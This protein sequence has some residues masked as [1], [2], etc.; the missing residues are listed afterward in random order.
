MNPVRILVYCDSRETAE[1][2]KKAI[3]ELANGN[4]KKGVPII[5]IDTELFVGARRVKERLDASKKLK[6]LGFLA[7]GGVTVKKPAFLIAT[8]AGEVGIDL[9]ADHM[10]CDLVPWERMV[11]R[12]G[13]VNR[14]DDGNAHIIVIDEG[15][16][17]PKNADK[18]SP[19]ERRDLIAS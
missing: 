3:E 9:D 6:D 13:R 15:E 10:V 11:Q 14:R 8:S 19:K 2:T 5:D 12:F 1:K 7:G 4:K 18:P 17:K 16:P